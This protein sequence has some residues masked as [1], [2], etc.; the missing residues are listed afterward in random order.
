MGLFF[1]PWDASLRLGFFP[2]P[3]VER[4]PI[5]SAP[6]YMCGLRALFISDVHLRRCV[7]DAKLSTL[8]HLITD[9]QADLILLGGDY[10]ETDDQ[11]ARFFEA[12]RAVSVPL[13]CFGV[14]GNNDDRR[15]LSGYMSAA[16]VEL[17]L[18]RSI[19]L[20]LPSGILQIGGCDEYKFGS[21]D[22]RSL[23]VGD[24]YRILLSHFPVRPACT[25]EL[26]LAG[27]THGGQMNLLGF[28]P[29]SLGFEH[30]YRL[31]AVRGLHRLDD[32][33][34]LVCNGVGVSRLPVRLGARPQMLMIEF[35]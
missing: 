18:N 24:G 17:L 23:F 33:Q 29:Y 15:T 31:M 2:L 11:C 22:T 9:Q 14:I 4:V 7:S 20:P 19:T 34:L 6:A 8:M 1:P 30:H 28:T 35:D 16:G 27:H 12:F 21:P 25:A 13:G 10:A 3:R 5:S 32:M 26:M